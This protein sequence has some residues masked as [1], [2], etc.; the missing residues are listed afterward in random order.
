MHACYGKSYRMCLVE[1]AT[2]PFGYGVHAGEVSK[3]Y[4]PDKNQ[5]TPARYHISGHTFNLDISLSYGSAIENSYRH[6]GSVFEPI[7]TIV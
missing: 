5:A 2:N 6:S 3:H 1:D 7:N 4:A